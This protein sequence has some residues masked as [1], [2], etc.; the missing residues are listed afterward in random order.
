MSMDKRKL[1]PTEV[2]TRIVAMGFL[3]SL[4]VNPV[5]AQTATGSGVLNNTTVTGFD[6]G[7]VISHTRLIEDGQVVGAA[8]SRI[9]KGGNLSFGS[10]GAAAGAGGIG[11]LEGKHFS[12]GV[13]F[14]Y[15]SVSDKMLVL[16]NL[17]AIGFRDYE[18]DDFGNCVKIDELQ[19][20]VTVLPN[21]SEAEKKKLK[22]LSS[23][24]PEIKNGRFTLEIEHLGKMQFS[25]LY[26][27]GEAFAAIPK[28]A[29]SVKEINKLDEVGDTLLLRASRKKMWQTAE[30][31]L[32]NGAK[33]NV[34]NKKGYTALMFAAQSGAIE[35]VSLLLKAGADVSAKD[36]DGDTA[37]GWAKKEE[38][39]KLLQGAIIEKK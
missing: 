36:E 11:A 17:I 6:E 10:G 8:Y 24:T 2:K 23:R 20:T 18:W 13:W 16:T 1:A 25:T 19:D 26:S 12:H 22:I 33:V 27:Q 9:K 38:I 29:V 21:S 3:L 35:A 15:P 37:F 7:M 5:C 14:T 31:L 34:Q 4:A 30:Y 32:Q 28:G 39:K